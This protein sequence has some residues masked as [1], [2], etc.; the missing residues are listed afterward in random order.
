MSD[1]PHGLAH[2]LDQEVKGYAQ[3]GDFPGS[4]KETRISGAVAPGTPENVP[5][6]GTGPSAEAGA[7]FVLVAKEHQSM[8]QYLEGG[9][10]PTDAEEQATKEWLLLEPENEHPTPLL[11][12]LTSMSAIQKGS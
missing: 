4:P 5:A 12:D 10:P 7:A 8:V 2:W 11:R 9:L 1:N 3:K 6:L